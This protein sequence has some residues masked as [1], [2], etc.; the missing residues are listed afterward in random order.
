MA[1][2]LRGTGDR[3][4]GSPRILQL[5]S[6]NQRRGAESAAVM[7]AEALTCRGYSTR[8]VALAQADEAVLPGVPVL[9]RHTLGPR[10]LLRLRAEV[11][12]ADVVI[13]HGSRTLPAM[14]AAAAGLRRRL[15][16]QNIGDPLFWAGDPWRRRRVRFLLARTSAVAALTE[17]TA[18]VLHDYLGVPTDRLHTIR[19]M[20]DGRRFRPPTDAERDEAR[21]AFGLA[22]DD[23]AVAVVGALSP[24]KRVDLAL[25]AGARVPGALVLVAGDGPERAALERHAQRSAGRVRFLGSLGD[26]VTLLHASDVVLMTSESEGVPGVLVEAGLCGV[27]AVSTDVGYVADVVADG[28]TGLLVG[29]DDAAEIGAAVVSVL[30]DGDRMGAAARRRC[31]ERF[32]LS[33]VLEEWTRLLGPPVSGRPAPPST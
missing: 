20:R 11:R 3:P 27:P 6:R 21:A 30:A 8:L 26:V 12:A 23:R 14:V 13:G 2:R 32:E 29:S 18:A 17:Q 19:N 33:T 15:V 31:V 16:Y 25:D 7:L 22:P 4:A 10:T 24:E 9:G 5:I 28:D 1:D